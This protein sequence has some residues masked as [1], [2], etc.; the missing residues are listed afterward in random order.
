MTSDQK[1]L[2][3]TSWK[4]VSPISSTAADLFYGR[5][6]ELD[7][8]LRKLFPEDIKEQKLKLMQTL[9]YC[10]HG[11]DHLDQIVSNVQA[12]G[13]RHNDYHVKP[14]D[15]PTVGTALLW[16]LEQGLGPAFTDETRQAWIEVYTILSGVMIEAA[17]QS[18]NAIVE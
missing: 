16:T 10:V 18:P 5:L 1:A 15:Y 4:L 11:L 2:V 7:P 13:I 17:Q 9:A 8:S 12:L 3:Q 14:A 6:F